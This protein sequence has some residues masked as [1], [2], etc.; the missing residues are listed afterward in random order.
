M[1]KILTPGDLTK[2]FLDAAKPRKVSNRFFVPE[3]SQPDRLNKALAKCVG[4]ED[5]YDDNEVEE[6]KK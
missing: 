1:K 4:R 3:P 5:L 6:N 2:L